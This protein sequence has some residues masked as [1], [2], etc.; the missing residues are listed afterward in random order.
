[1]KSPSAAPHKDSSQILKE[2]TTR[3]EY[4]LARNQDPFPTLCNIFIN[5][6]LKYK[7]CLF[8]YLDSILFVGYEV[9]AC[10]HSGISA[11]S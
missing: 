9:D 2:K 4:Q 3:D 5:H 6:S 8:A 10:L 7:A 1:M 11:L